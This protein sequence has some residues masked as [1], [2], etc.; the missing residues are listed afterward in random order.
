MQVYDIIMLVILVSATL[1][2]AWKGLAWQLASLAAI[3]ASYYVA[4]EFRDQVAGMIDASPPWN[5]FLAMLLL[6]VGCSML[7][8]LT[9]RFVSAFIDR[10]R[11]KE[12]DRQIGALLGFAKGVVLCILIT[13]F[14]VALL[15]ESQ[16]QSIIQSYSGRRIAQLLDRADG[17]IPSEIHDVLHPYHEVLHGLGAATRRI[18]EEPT[19]SPDP[20]QFLVPV[21]QLLD[22]AVR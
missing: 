10:L 13:L 1:F 3:F 5:V 21:E 9:F 4:I 15:G 17:V 6:Y 14:G 19:A 22:S 18:A 7:I 20:E 11:L 16:R 8:W 2:G 12:F